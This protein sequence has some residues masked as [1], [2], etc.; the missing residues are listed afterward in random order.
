MHP[1]RTRS[2]D[3]GGLSDA[4]PAG[5]RSEPLTSTSAVVA[6]PAT[7]RTASAGVPTCLPPSPP[8]PGR[9]NAHA[10]RSIDRLRKRQ[11]RARLAS[12]IPRPCLT[13]RAASAASAPTPASSRLPCPQAR[14]GAGPPASPGRD[15]TRRQQREEQ[16]RRQ[17]DRARRTPPP[18]A[19]TS[20]PGP[21]CGTCGGHR[22]PYTTNHD[23]AAHDRARRRYNGRHAKA[24]STGFPE[25]AADCRAKPSSSGPSTVCR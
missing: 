17:R 12:S 5:R 9:P 15:D 2:A 16:A 19:G 24:A 8:G 4:P 1:D 20:R 21:Y 13:T 6:S 3:P 18:H 22:G 14:P 11:E 23:Q 25:E 7:A 10:K